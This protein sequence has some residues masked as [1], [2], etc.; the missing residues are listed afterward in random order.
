MLES[1]L[2]SNERLQIEVEI[3]VA[4]MNLQANITLAPQSIRPLTCAIRL[5]TKI[6][7]YCNDTQRS[8]Y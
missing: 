7:T 6:L 4:T 2:R 8:N 1:K 5:G 3:T